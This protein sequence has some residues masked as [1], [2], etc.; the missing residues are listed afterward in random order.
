MVELRTIEPEAHS[1]VEDAH[2]A[3]CPA[4]S[5][6][7]PADDGTGYVSVSLQLRRLGLLAGVR[8]YVVAKPYTDI[9]TVAAF[10]EIA[11]RCP[12]IVRL[13]EIWLQPSVYEKWAPVTT[14]PSFL[15][16]KHLEIGAQIFYLAP[17]RA[18]ALIN[19][20]PGLQTLRLHNGDRGH[21]AS[22]QSRTLRELD[23]SGTSGGFGL[24]ACI[25]VSGLQVYS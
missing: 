21:E 6:P 4:T 18:Q 22:I 10:F 16:L 5:A 13:Q 19:C 17:A 25:C 3:Y 11:A 24:A 8:A 15:R 20:M 9:E 12:G 14:A 2:A 7:K 23:L 1:L